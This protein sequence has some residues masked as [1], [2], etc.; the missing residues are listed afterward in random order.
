MPDLSTIYP[1]VQPLGGF[2]GGLVQGQQFLDAQANQEANQRA[3]M[4]DYLFKQQ[5]QP[6]DLRQA[7]ANVGHTNALTRQSNVT[8]DA[9]QLQNDWENR[10]KDQKYQQQVEEWARK[11]DDNEIHKTMYQA[12]QDL[13]SGDKDRVKR[14]KMIW[15][16]T[17]DIMKARQAQEAAYRQATSVAQIGSEGRLQ[18]IREKANVPIKNREGL[19]TKLTQLMQATDDPDLQQMYA[20]Q[21]ADIRRSMQEDANART[22]AIII[23]ADGKVV[24]N[25]QGPGTV[26][27]PQ[28]SAKPKT[29]L[30]LDNY[31]K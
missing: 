19:V 24:P 11:H 29:P 25:P 3:A 4:Q 15:E 21:I 9:T 10:T 6:I 13:W 22:P 8:A 18:G 1:Q 23:G 26:T 7:E 28:V 12:Q 31:R 16:M 17:T 5:K 30:N 20:S 14:G 2:A 27:P